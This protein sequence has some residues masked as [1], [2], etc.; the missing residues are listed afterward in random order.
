[1]TSSERL[2]QI[3]SLSDIAKFVVAAHADKTTPFAE[4]ALQG[5]EVIFQLQEDEISRLSENLH[6]P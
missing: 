2:A 5:L 6:R 1:M 4:R 3:Q